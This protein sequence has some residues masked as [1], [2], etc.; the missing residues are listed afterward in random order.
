MSV[1]TLV[2]ALVVAVILMHQNI[3][4]KFVIIDGL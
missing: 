2:I 3:L 4:T 1:V